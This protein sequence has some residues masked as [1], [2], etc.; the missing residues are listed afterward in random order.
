M[1]LRSPAV[2]LLFSFALFV[3]AAHSQANIDSRFGTVGQSGLGTASLWQWWRGYNQDY[4]FISLPKDAKRLF[5]VGKLDD[6]LRDLGVNDWCQP[7]TPGVDRVHPFNCGRSSE[8]PFAQESR[9]DGIL[10]WDKEGV[11]KIIREFSKQYRQGLNSEHGYNAATEIHFSIGNEPNWY[12]YVSPIAYARVYKAYYDFIKAPAP[13]GLGCASCRIHNGGILLANWRL[14]GVLSDILTGTVSVA[15]EL[16]GLPFLWR[17]YKGGVEKSD[18]DLGYLEWTRRFLVELAH[19]HGTV[20]IFDAHAYDIDI[21][22]G[23]GAFL[24][25][26]NPTENLRRFIAMIR[27][28]K[29]AQ[30]SMLDISLP[31][32]QYTCREGCGRNGN[33]WGLASAGSGGCMHYNDKEIIFP[34]DNPCTLGSRVVSLNGGTQ[35]IVVN[36]P[37]HY[38]N[39]VVWVDEFGLVRNGTPSSGAISSMNN[40]VT[41]FKSRPEVER[42]FWYKN[43]GEDLFFSKFRALSFGLIT[44]PAIALFTDD[45]L[46]ALTAVG[47]NYLALQQSVNVTPWTTATPLPAPYANLPRYIQ[48]EDNI[49]LSFDFGSTKTVPRQGWTFPSNHVLHP[50]GITWTAPCN[51]GISKNF[52]PEETEAMKGSRYFVLERGNFVYS[53]GDHF[54]FIV[55]NASGIE[56]HRIVGQLWGTIVNPLSNQGEAGAVDLSTFLQPGESIV[57]IVANFNTS[58]NCQQS[59]EQM[60]LGLRRAYFSKWD[61]VP[62]ES[63]K[64]SYN[65]AACRFS[66]VTTIRPDLYAAKRLSIPINMEYL[67]SGCSFSLDAASSSKGISVVKQALEWRPSAYMKGYHAGT[68]TLTCGSSVINKPFGLTI[69]PAEINMTAI[70]SLLLY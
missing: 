50:D 18:A 54:D 30:Q 58:L 64:I 15:G 13:T 55:R 29:M 66:G 42:W 40:M 35:P 26:E 28:G 59:S 61:P 63:W 32:G 10:E 1:A 47:Q 41:Y 70:N 17:M 56:S 4:N 53:D 57:A 67:A 14:D 16:T 9:Y 21:G 51:S 23:P 11:R 69:K 2:S 7:N 19:L 33:Q 25:K 24:I 31:A 43:T 49:V 20:D 22:P 60:N 68:L 5:T 45:G 52:T 3:S 39:P 8:P 37:Y 44:S 27:G 65:A 12:P 36:M 6:P 62:A 38:P 48:S 46:A 34:D